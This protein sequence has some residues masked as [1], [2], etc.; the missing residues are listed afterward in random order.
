LSFP[1]FYDITILLAG[2]K[3][4]M[5]KKKIQEKNPKYKPQNLLLIFKTQFSIFNEAPMI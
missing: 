4:S 5:G 3:Y 1:P 2:G